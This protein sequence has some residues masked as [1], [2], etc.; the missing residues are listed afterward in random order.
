MTFKIG[1]VDGVGIY[2]TETDVTIKVNEYPEI[3]NYRISHGHPG[4]SKFVLETNIFFE[5]VGEMDED[6]KSEEKALFDSAEDAITP[7]VKHI[8]KLIGRDKAK[9]KR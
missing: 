1:K 3:T 2:M 5:A 6:I 9:L 8:G 4:F 7:I